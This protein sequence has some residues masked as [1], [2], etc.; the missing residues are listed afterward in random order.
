MTRARKSGASVQLLSFARLGRARRPSPHKP[1][2]IATSRASLLT[3]RIRARTFS[4]LRQ[5]MLGSGKYLSLD[6]QVCPV[7][8]ASRDGTDETENCPPYDKALRIYRDSLWGSSSCF[9]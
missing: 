3:H 5:R 4:G 7:R 2:P 1:M 9:G 8:A 6:R